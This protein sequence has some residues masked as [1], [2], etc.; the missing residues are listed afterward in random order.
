MSALTVRPFRR[1][2]RDQLTALV[3][4]HAAAVVPGATASVNT[5]LGSLERRPEEY[6]TDPWVAERAT[7]VA[8]RDGR[9]VAA[10]HL[11]R[12]RE[13]PEV[14]PDYRGTGQVSW[15][16][17]YPEAGGTEAAGAA[18]GGDAGGG[19]AG[20]LLASAC[21]ARLTR[22]RVRARYADGALPVPGVYGIPA[23]WPHVRAT[24]ERA[25]FVP[26]GGTEILLIAPVAA[27]PAPAVAPLPGYTLHRTLGE[28]GTTRLTA[29]T[30]GTDTA[31][32]E[33]DTTLDRPERRARSGGTADI[34]DL[35]LPDDAVPG[36]LPWL[37]G[38]ARRWLELCGVDRVLAYADPEESADIAALSAH[39]FTELTRTER[40]WEHR[41][42]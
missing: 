39:G 12:Y 7:L 37:L 29:R 36:L 17:H 19:H 40:G 1:E 31:F 11:L 2:D 10:A 21:L 35:E 24:L 34:A 5:V 30:D 33:L 8:E 41:P 27:L 16:L 32:V 38:E 15:L 20:D 14:G 42:A 28:L 18:A 4:A 22:W 13:D 6:I 25:G 23:P 3:N 26:T 9:I